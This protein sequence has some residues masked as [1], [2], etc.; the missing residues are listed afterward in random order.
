MNTNR[1]ST[2][3]AGIL[4]IVGI[5]AGGLSIV[6]AIEQPNYLI[7]A[8]SHENQIFVGAFFQL[9]MIPAY[10]GFALYL[11]PVLKIKNEVLSLGF[12]GFRLI[13]GMFHFIG[14]ILL[15]LFLILSQEFVVAGAPEASYFQVMGELL[16]MG[17]DLVNHV[18]LILSL[19]IADLL[20]FIILYQSK[21][22][23][24]WLSLWGVFGLG[25]TMVASFL[26]LFQ[27]IAVVTPIYI[28]MNVPLILQT[29]IFTVWLILKGFDLDNLDL[30]SESQDLDSTVKKTV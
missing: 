20:L 30:D 26:V 15:P 19:S 28:A 2:I 16:R 17:R 5:I 23:P 22:V 3:I 11:Y 4:T 6:P 29:L 7:L 18:A 13:V 9:L 21:L 14:V 10:V 12:V 8:S 25:L 24:R 1:R 27:L